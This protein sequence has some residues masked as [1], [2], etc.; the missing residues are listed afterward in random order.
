MTQASISVEL[1]RRDTVLDLDARW[2]RLATQ[3]KPNG[4]LSWAW[5]DALESSYRLADYVICARKNDAIVGMGVFY[6]KRRWY[7]QDIWYLNRSGIDQY[8]QAWIEF[9]DFLLDLSCEEEVRNALLSFLKQ[10]V[11]N[12]S[13]LHLGASRPHLWQL[14]RAD[15]QLVSELKWY[16]NGYRADLSRFLSVE[17]YL[18]SLSSNTRAQIR[19]SV[20]Y[21]RGLG[22]LNVS[23]ADSA[24]QTAEWFEH[25]AQLHKLRWGDKQGQSGFSNSR[26]VEFHQVLLA[27][28]SSPGRVYKIQFGHVLLAYLY[29]LEVDGHLQFYLSAVDYSHGRGN[30][31][32]PGLVA[33]YVMI[34]QSIMRNANVYDFLGGDARYKHSLSHD[35]YDLSIEQFY[36]KSKLSHCLSWFKGLIAAHRSRS[37]QHP[38]IAAVITSTH[39]GNEYFAISITNSKIVFVKKQC[40]VAEDTSVMRNEMS[41]DQHKQLIVIKGK[42][43]RV[44]KVVNLKLIKDL[45]ANR[46]KQ[47]LIKGDIL[48]I[49]SSDNQED[50]AML[51]AIHISSMRMIASHAVTG[52]NLRLVDSSENV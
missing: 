49:I 9:N 24:E 40:V 2:Q 48:L 36:V 46:V 34:E 5:L 12:T 26:F 4:F 39:K 52:R 30:K 29:F 11:L 1:V 22:A 13:R 50:N 15:E 42:S 41:V 3:A 20:K 44:D 10:R 7:A 27:H 43:G 14:L 25:I 21:Y 23:W 33:H 38:N 51:V 37:I 18:N 17:D 6:V 35:C 32:K 45:P 16:T 28:K 19:R 8:D 31:Y 47:A